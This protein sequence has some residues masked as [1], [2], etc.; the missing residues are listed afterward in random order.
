[1]KIIHLLA[2]CL[3]GAS[4][5]GANNGCQQGA[6]KC[7]ASRTP[8]AAVYKKVAGPASCDALKGEK[9]GINTYNP[10]DGNARPNLS[11]ASIAIQTESLGTL[12]DDAEK[13]GL[14]DPNKAHKPYALGVITNSNAEPVNNFCS[15]P[16]LSVALQEFPEQPEDKAMMVDAVPARSVQY[17]WSNVQLYVTPI[18]LG[19][20]F[21]A[22]LR[23][24]DDAVECTYRVIGLSPYV[25]CG[26]EDPN[27]PKKQIVDLGA[28]AP[29]P[30]VDAGRATGSGI[31]P[32]L[33]VACDPELFV[34]VLTKD[35]LPA[36]K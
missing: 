1:M 11:K 21:S 18:K 17:V 6:V 24:T 4:I 36:L 30:N 10:D 26:V 3:L 25:P 16:E 7:A 22:D 19:T 13:A 31:D 12:G 15:V 27:D 8:F 14:P 5:V 9:V 35:S 29:E 32:D 33:A 34:C 20:Q 28:C 2:T 23:L